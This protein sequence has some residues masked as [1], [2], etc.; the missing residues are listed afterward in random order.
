MAPVTFCGGKKKTIRPYYVNPWCEE[1]LTIDAPRLA[2]DNPVENPSI[3][4]Y[5]ALA[6]GGEFKDLARVPLRWKDNLRGDCTAFPTRPG[7]TDLPAVFKVP[8]ADPA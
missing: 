1:D 3:G 8:G 5:Q 2:P 4:H 6:V 7:F